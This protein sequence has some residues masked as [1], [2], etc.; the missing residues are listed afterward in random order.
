MGV[1]DGMTYPL[2][3]DHVRKALSVTVLWFV[4]GFY[5]GILCGEWLMRYFF[6]G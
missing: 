3:V 2:G 4:V 6:K 1:G 5:F